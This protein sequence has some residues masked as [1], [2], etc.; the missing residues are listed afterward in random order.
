MIFM[1]KI[2]TIQV[3]SDNQ[4]EK[5]KYESLICAYQCVMQSIS[6]LEYYYQQTE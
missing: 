6:G 4:Y 1:G 2:D 3:L 5:E